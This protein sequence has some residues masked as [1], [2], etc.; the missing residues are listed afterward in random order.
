MVTSGLP[1]SDLAYA[2]HYQAIKLFQEKKQNY[3]EAFENSGIYRLIA[4]GKKAL[5]EGK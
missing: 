1:V 3:F 2:M 5:S 4:E